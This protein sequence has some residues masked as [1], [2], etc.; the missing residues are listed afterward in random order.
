MPRTPTRARAGFRRP[1]HPD[2]FSARSYVVTLPEAAASTRSRWS[3]GAAGTARRPR[4]VV[5]DF[6]P[7]ARLARVDLLALV[8][9][10]ETQIERLSAALVVV[11]ECAVL[12]ADELDA[13]D[14]LAVFERFVGRDVGPP[15][16]GERRHRLVREI[17]VAF[18]FD[19]RLAVGTVVGDRE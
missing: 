12:A 11:F 15:L 10:D 8:E 9:L 4:A 3:R 5:G 7:L 14:V 17:A 16:E 13:V 18:E 19:Q 2:R 6:D 1:R